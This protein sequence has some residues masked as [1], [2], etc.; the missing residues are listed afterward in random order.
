MLNL[1]DVPTAVDDTATTQEDMGVI[2][3][4]ANLLAN[5]RLAENSDDDD[6]LSVSGVEN[7]DD[8]TV[9]LAGEGKGKWDGGG[10]RQFH[11][12]ARGWR[13]HH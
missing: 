13:H 3:S 9:V 12:G 1:A 5:D 6:A 4:A 8:G 10:Q 11:P 7:G 2:I